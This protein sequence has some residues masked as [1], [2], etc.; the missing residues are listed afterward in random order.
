MSRL[1]PLQPHYVIRAVRADDY[2]GFLDMRA[3]AGPGFTSL[4]LDDKKLAARIAHSEASFA[5]RPG[6]P[7]S[8]RYVL[9]LEHLESASLAGTAALKA[10]VGAEPP[11]FN[12]R[13]LTIAQ[14][15]HAVD[16]RFDMEVLI[17]VNEFTGCSEVGSLFLRA[18]H[19]ASGIGRSLAQAR[20]M[21]MALAPERFN[22]RVVSELRGVVTP[23]GQSPFWDALGRHFFRMEFREADRLSATTD[24]Q[25]ILDLM[26]KYPIYADLLP[27]SARAV[28]GQCHPDGVPA[29]KLLEWEGF[30]YDHVVDIFEGGP[31]VSAARDNIRTKREA[32]R[33]KIKA[34]AAPSAP[35]AAL[36]ATGAFQDFRCVS[37]LAELA[38]GA[39]NAHPDA[40]RALQ[41][42][43]GAEILAWVGDAA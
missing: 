34:N 39:V 22:E 28:I 25:F 33:M 19:R 38:D 1:P 5:A 9:A 11:F 32:R 42:E 29:R 12:F 13:V 40:L 31:L 36:I 20:Y 8:E 30:R 16:R 21:L 18:E 3:L 17:L 4:M 10:T 23:D 15:S 27:D 26:P 43:E 41:V 24:N 2:A 6:Q 35:R 14:A 37:V 7:G